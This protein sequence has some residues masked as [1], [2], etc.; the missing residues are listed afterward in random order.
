MQRFHFLMSTLFDKKVKKEL[1]RVARYLDQTCK[2]SKQI[3]PEELCVDQPCPKK[4]LIGGTETSKLSPHN[5]HI[6]PCAK[7]PPNKKRERAGR[8]L[9]PIFLPIFCLFFA[10]EESTGRRR[11]QRAHTHTYYYMPCFGIFFSQ[12]S[13]SKSRLSHSTLLTYSNIVYKIL[14]HT[15]LYFFRESVI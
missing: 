4:M 10:E 1:D 5:P 13:L 14:Q 8:L 9:L 3:Y 7:K 11:F 15:L 6:K 12:Q 2:M